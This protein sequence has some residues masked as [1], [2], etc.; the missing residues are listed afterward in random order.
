MTEVLANASQADEEDNF[1]G[2]E[3][4]IDSE[5]D[6]NEHIQNQLQDDEASDIFET[7]SS[8]NEDDDV[9]RR[10]QGLIS[11]EDH[12]QQSHDDKIDISSKIQA[13]PTTQQPEED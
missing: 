1:D 8:V 2:L 3:Q 4:I 10:L 11:C 9:Q 5:D 7:D 12:S 13:P 6:R